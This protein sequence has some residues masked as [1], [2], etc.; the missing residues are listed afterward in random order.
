M[1]HSRIIESS[2]PDEFFTLIRPRYHKPT[3]TQRGAFK[4]R[5]RL[6]ECGRLYAQQRDEYLARVVRVNTSRP[7]VL[8][9]TKPG[10]PIFC[11]GAEVGYDNLLQYNGDTTYM[12]R[13]SG[14]VAWGAMTLD[15]DEMQTVHT[16]HLGTTPEHVD[17]FRVITPPTVA[18]ARLRYLHA[19]LTILTNIIGEQ[20]V[21]VVPQIR[22]EEMLIKIM[23]DN[24]TMAEMRP[25]TI[26]RQHHHLIINR[27]FEALEAHPGH[28][29]SMPAL[30]R[31]IGVSSRTFRMACQEQLGV[32]P[33]HYLLLRRMQLARRA[34]READPTLT[35]VTDI[36]TEF[37]FWELGRFAVK[38]HQIFGET[39]S[40]TLRA[41]E[42]GSV[43]PQI[44]ELCRCLSSTD[45]CLFFGCVPH[46]PWI[47]R[48]GCKYRENDDGAKRHGA[49]PRFDGDDAAKLDESA[50]EC[51]HEDVDHRPPANPANY[52][53]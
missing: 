16:A 4:A 17:G 2:D 18:L 1:F 36:A 45:V 40:A 8:F 6:F 15:S 52:V 53:V 39:P 47:K 33:T 37:G 46:D 12:S 10:P 32:S 13:L 11:N 14:P 28:P 22:L 27:F 43:R 21:S 7:G 19:R 24:I 48:L 30:S 25:D 34:L 49:D 23:L 26:A 5:A 31:K 41:P 38:Y 20:V 29:L 50:E 9:L 42:S 35:R 3:V 51:L 44:L